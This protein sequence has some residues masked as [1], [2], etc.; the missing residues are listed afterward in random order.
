MKSFI[1]M[2]NT[3]IKKFGKHFKEKGVDAYLIWDMERSRNVNLKYISG[4]PEDAILIIF[5]DGKKVLIPWDV[6]LAKKL[7]KVDRIVDYK[8]NG[9]SYFGAA[10]IILKEKLGEKFTLEV[11][12]SISH[13]T[14][15]FWRKLLK[16]AKVKVLRPLKESAGAYL[17]KMRMIKTEE[18]IKNIKK[19]CMITSHVVE[20]IEKFLK[21]KKSKGILKEIDLAIFAE[22]K[23]REYGGD[24]IAFETL[25]ACPKRSWSIHTYPK[26]GE[27]DLNKAGLSLIDFGGSYHGYC[28]DVTL[29]F[30]MVKIN[31]I[32]RKMTD[33]VREAQKAAISEIKPGI[34]AHQIAEIAHRILKDAK[35]IMPHGLGHGLGLETHDPGGFALKPEDENLKKHWKPLVLKE[36]MIFTVEPG[37]YD[38]KHGGFRIEDDI[39]VTKNGC[40]L[41]TNS[42]F[43]E[44]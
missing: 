36:N 15:Q 32:Q 18:E 25:V 20:S 27:G 14:L 21:R 5:S 13:L 17:S 10:K 28:S 43:I 31:K 7:S 1:P 19:A 44:L 22:N 29:P 35:M 41:L 12:S 23:I 24:G 3:K 9:K 8:N 37:A 38:V 30:S 6:I 34:M 11:E 40:E 4:H 26:A 2:T 42:R 39:L 16:P 33:V